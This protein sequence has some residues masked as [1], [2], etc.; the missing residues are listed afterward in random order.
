MKKHIFIPFFLFIIVVFTGS[1]FFME[2][3]I[4]T[5]VKEAFNK[6]NARQISPFLNDMVNMFFEDAEGTYSRSQ[7]ELILVDFFSKN[8]PKIFEVNQE[9]IT[10]D[11]AEFV[12][13]TY[14]TSYG[15]KYRVYYLIKKD[16]T[17][18][19]RERIYELKISK[20]KQCQSRN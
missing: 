14:T 18:A 17:F 9:G 15:C 19:K 12:I 7:A 6:G 10:K 2:N 16:N 11:N 1:V 4:K 13:A 3:S 8:P 5:E 20:S